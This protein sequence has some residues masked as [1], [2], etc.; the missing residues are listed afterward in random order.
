MSGEWIK[1]TGIKPDLQD[2]TLVDIVLQNG[3]EIKEVE[4]KR[5]HWGETNHLGTN[6]IVHWRI[7]QGEPEETPTQAHQ[8][9]EAGA[10][11][12]RDRAK[13]YDK[14]GDY[15]SGERSIDATVEAFKAI[16]GDG[17]M[18]SGERGWMFMLLLKLVRSQAGEFKLDTYEDAAAYAG[19]MGESAAV[20]RSK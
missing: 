4:I 12:M 9:L 17:Q 5:L 10:K 3:D 20:E 15:D 1:N 6:T 16:T 18:D 7:A 13:T 8:I 14:G 2:D 19:L 11:H